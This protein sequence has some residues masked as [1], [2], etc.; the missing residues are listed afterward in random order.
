MRALFALLCLLP[1]LAQAAS[2]IVA[3]ALFKG[4][5]MLTIDGQRYTLKE[6]ESA[7]G[8]TLVF[9]DTRL[10]IVEVNG[11]RRELELSSRISTDFEQPEK[12]SVAII[13][14]NKQQYITRGTL[15]GRAVQM[16]VDTGANIVVL[17]SADADRLGIRYKNGTPGHVTTAGGVV[18]SFGINLDSVNVGGIEVR[19]VRAVVAE[20]DF[21]HRILLGMTYLTHVNFRENNGILYLER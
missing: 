15:N 5:A 8:V 17:S 7:D 11:E 1:L 18:K 12:Q 21:P 16:L 3:E 10:A 4:G 19:N 13:R 6:G 9:A 14:N 20:G 2:D